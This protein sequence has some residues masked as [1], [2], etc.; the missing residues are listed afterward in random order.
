ME[1]KGFTLIELMIVVAIV[2]IL[3]AVAIFPMY[4]DYTIRSRVTEGLSLASSAKLAVAETATINN[5]LPIDQAS[6]G[7]TSPAAT[8]NVASIVIGA[9]GVITITYTPLAGNGTLVLTPTMLPTGDFT[10]DCK[11][12][13]LLIKYRPTSCR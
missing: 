10:W 11:G 12:G 3:V 5:E 7:Y 9:N 2:A 8:N 6:T 1:Q 13:S 4:Q